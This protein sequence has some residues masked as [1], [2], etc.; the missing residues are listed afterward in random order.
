MKKYVSL[1]VLLASIFSCNKEKK[2]RGNSFYQ[3]MLSEPTTLNPITSADGYASQ[4]QSYI[5]ESLLDRDEDTYEYRP[6]LAESW[7]ISGDKKVF[8]FN[9]RQ[10]VT[11]HDG[12]PF[13]AEDVKF[14]LDVI[15]DDAYNAAHKRPYFE[16]LERV[17]VI[18]PYKVKF[19]TKTKYY[20]N[21]DSAAGLTIVPKHIYSKDKENKKLNRILVG[22]GPYVLKKYDK[23][24]KIILEKNKFWWG[25]KV[26]YLKGQHNF[27]SIGLR[28]VGDKTVALEMLKK[29]NLDFKGLDAEEYM[30]NT[31]GDE[32]G[33]EYIKVKVENKSP[34][35]YNFYGWNLKKKIFQD[36]RVRRALAHLVNRPLMLDKFEYNLSAYAT[37]PQYVQSDYA[38]KKVKPIL[39]DPKKALELLNEAGWSDSDGDLV[40]DKMID[41]KKVDFKFSVIDPYEGFKK[42]NTIFKED[43]RKVGINVEL[44]VVEWNTFTKLL[45]EKNF[46]VV[47]LAW[48]GGGVDWEP[49]QIWHSSSAVKGG[50]NFISYSNPEVDRLIEEAREIYDKS[51]RIEVLKKVY[52]MI[53]DDAPYAFFFNR[54]ETLYAHRSRIQKPKDT[55]MYSIGINHWKVVE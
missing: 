45:D 41:G 7:E 28:F 13:T 11:W 23:G 30:N 52:E 5:L 33:K 6:A 35:G 44:K 17:E 43:C 34:K 8:T 22:T 27:E 26:D 3:S 4:V 46:D 49:K 16:G 32:W 54:N 42:Y 15:F 1:M 12:E 55:F 36:K 51:K 14:S 48:G 38:S 39:Y 21:F 53:A 10:N 2:F 9:L 40:L 50:S 20:K 29:G 31:S 19:Y 18:S 37:G 24:K 47:R 25:N